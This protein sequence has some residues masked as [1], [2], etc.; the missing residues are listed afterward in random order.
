MEFVQLRLSGGGTSLG[1][2]RDGVYSEVAR[3]WQELHDFVKLVVGHTKEQIEFRVVD[4]IN[5]SPLFVDM[6][7]AT[8]RAMEDFPGL[9]RRQVY[10][11]IRIAIKGG[12]I[13]GVTEYYEKQWLYLPGLEAWLK[14]SEDD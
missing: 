12:K 2:L 13:D 6:S 10:E 5:I 7:W 9:E 1:I 11:K 3:S 14:E 8:D 4:P